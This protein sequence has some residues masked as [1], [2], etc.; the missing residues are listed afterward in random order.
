[1]R[2][3]IMLTQPPENPAVMPS[4]PPISSAQATGVTPMNSDSRPP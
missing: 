4:P 3:I 1:M 2:M